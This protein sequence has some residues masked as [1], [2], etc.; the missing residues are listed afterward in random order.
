[1]TSPLLSNVRHG[2]RVNG[3]RTKSRERLLGKILFYSGLLQHERESPDMERNYMN[4][5]KA[6]TREPELT[7]SRR[8]TVGGGTNTR[9]VPEEPVCRSRHWAEKNTKNRA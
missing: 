6:Q 1:M 8:G 5:D 9:A 3:E 2:A 4:S 7:T